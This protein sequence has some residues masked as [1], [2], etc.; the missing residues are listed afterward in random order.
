MD[1]S[2]GWRIAAGCCSGRTITPRALARGLEPANKSLRIGGKARVPRE[3]LTIGLTSLST[4][5]I[6]Q[7]GT[8]ICLRMRRGTRRPRRIASWVLPTV[9]DVSGHGEEMPTNANLN[10]RPARRIELSRED[11]GEL[12]ERAERLPT[13]HLDSLPGWS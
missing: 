3:E 13:L 6:R 5:V 9:D 2:G 12:F 10:Q 7:P 8:P 4:G 11:V 1:A